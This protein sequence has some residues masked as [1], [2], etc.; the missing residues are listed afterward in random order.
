MSG[1][2]FNDFIFTHSSSTPSH[3][4]LTHRLFDLRVFLGLL[5]CFHLLLVISRARSAVYSKAWVRYCTWRRIRQKVFIRLSSIPSNTTITP[6][7]NTSAARAKARDQKK[8]TAQPGQ[9][10]QSRF[11]S[12]P[13]L[14]TGKKRKLLISFNKPQNSS[15]SPALC[16]VP[17]PE[18]PLSISAA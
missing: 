3:L 18:A 11:N 7:A 13:S 5:D 1:F 17:N 8:R 9:F 16:V 6:E 2:N 10:L 4:E 12:L 14:S 15:V